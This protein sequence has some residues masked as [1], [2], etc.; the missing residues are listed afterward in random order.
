[1]ILR[2]AEEHNEK[3]WSVPYYS[4][5]SQEGATVQLRAENAATTDGD[6]AIRISLQD[7]G[8]GIAPEH[9]Q[10]IFE[11]FY[12]CDKARSRQDGGTGLGLAIV[13]HIAGAHNGTVELQSRLGKGSTFS[14]ILP[15]SR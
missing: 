14:I 1:M 11:R 15:A 10:R 5:Y 2:V 4:P 12:R 6:Q 7:Q 13:K 9:Q 8:P 3:T